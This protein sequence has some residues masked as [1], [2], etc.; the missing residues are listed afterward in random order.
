MT[1]C[2][3]Y[4]Q[5]VQKFGHKCWNTFCANISPELRKQL[6]KQ[7]KKDYKNEITRFKTKPT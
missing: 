7:L 4:D 6:K 3:Y 1:L 2:Q 5:Y